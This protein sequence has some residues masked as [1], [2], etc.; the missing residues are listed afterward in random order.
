[1]RLVV[2]RGQFCELMA[3]LFGFQNKEAQSLYL[4]GMF[5]LLDAVLD[6]PMEKVFNE[7]PLNSEI[8]ETI[9]GKKTIYRDILDTS[10]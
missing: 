8:T 5:S 7:V 2:K 4:I 6:L 3:P 9:L 1:M 10:I